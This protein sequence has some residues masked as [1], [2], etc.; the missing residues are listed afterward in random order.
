MFLNSDN[1]FTARG[2][3]VDNPFINISQETGNA[4][5][6]ITLAQ[7]HPFKKKG[8]GT[9]ETVFINYTAIDTQNNKIA[10]RLA[11]YVVK[12]S[13]VSLVG[14]HD[15]Y[16]KTNEQ[17]KKEYLETKRILQFRNEE[18]KERT[19]ERRKGKV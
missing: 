5:V 10:S 1:Q 15:S 16:V 11:D 13:L 17:G 14:F 19:E 18:S 7:D 9:K 4:I 12:G 2:R 8:D 3:L 6:S